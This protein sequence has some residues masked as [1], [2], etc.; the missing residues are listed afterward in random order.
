MAPRVFVALAALA[1]AAA[2]DACEAPECVETCHLMPCPETK[3]GTCRIFG[4]D[5]KHGPTTCDA[6]VCHCAE[7][8]CPGP[9][10]F[11]C[12]E[13]TNK[14][15]SACH[16]KVG[17]CRLFGCSAK[18]GATDCVDGVCLCAGDTCS[19]DDY[20]CSAPAAP[21]RLSTLLASNLTLEESSTL[22]QAKSDY[23]PREMIPASSWL[24]A[25]AVSAV[26]GAAGV[27][28]VVL[29]KGNRGQSLV[30]PLI[31]A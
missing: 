9:D 13:N 7:G 5:P 6:G 28:T 24:M 25:A 12:V 22:L 3:V 23:G 4:C 10:S 21:T 2:E 29:W 8:T 19:E 15:C 31:E 26:G 20:T 16:K 27:L 30:E 14:V 1:L 18:H 17:T 11:T